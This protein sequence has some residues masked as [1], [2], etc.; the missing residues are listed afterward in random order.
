MVCVLS[1]YEKLIVLHHTEECIRTGHILF[2]QEFVSLNYPEQIFHLNTPKWTLVLD[3]E[4]FS[5]PIFQGGLCFY[6]D[7]VPVLEFSPS[8]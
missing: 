8:E 4:Q 2:E 3:Q 7:Q 5:E 6:L 1:L